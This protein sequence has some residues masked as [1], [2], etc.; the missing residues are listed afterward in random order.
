M[1]R[2]GAGRH[3]R[4]R[5]ADVILSLQELATML[6]SGVSIVDAVGSQVQRAFLQLQLQRNFGKQYAEL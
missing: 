1:C 5:H 4:L 3:G 2:A 6:T